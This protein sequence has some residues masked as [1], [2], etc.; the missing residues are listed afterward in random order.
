[1]EVLRDR[2]GIPHIR[3]EGGQADAFLAQGFVHAQDRLFQME[4]NRRRALGRAA[5]WL[6][7]AAA[8]GDVLARRLGM[9]AAC[10]RDHAALGAEA[11]EMVEAYAAGVNAFLASGAPRPI[12]Y[13]LLDATPEPWEGW[14]AIAVMRRLGLLMGSV[15]FKLWRAAALPLLGAERTRRLRYDDGGA[16]LLLLPPGVEAKR[17]TATL[18][19]LQPAIAA[20][21]GAEDADATGAAATTGRWTPRAARRGGP[22]SPAIPTGSSRSRTCTRRATSPAATSTSSA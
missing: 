9:E 8:E 1:V 5:E 18:A 2:W 21:L 12:E 15:W 16:D 17:W 6:G 3:A 13:E 11:R 22:S 20:L 19:E 4:L 10:R 14:H 7:P